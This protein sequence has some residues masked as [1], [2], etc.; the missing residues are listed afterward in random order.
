[1]VWAGLNIGMT[2]DY[3]TFLTMGRIYKVTSNFAI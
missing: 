3:K 2:N 1:M